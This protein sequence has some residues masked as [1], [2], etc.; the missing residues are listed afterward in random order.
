V[1]QP[2]MAVLLGCV[3]CNPVEEKG[4]VVSAD[5]PTPKS[6]FEQEWGEA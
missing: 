1:L 4:N 6:V 5:V 3:G 2:L